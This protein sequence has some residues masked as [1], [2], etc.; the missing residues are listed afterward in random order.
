[1]SRINVMNSPRLYLEAHTYDVRAYRARV[2]SARK[3]SPHEKAS[4]ITE[5]RLRA[6]DELLKGR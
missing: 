1:M 4:D 6:R 3:R 5:Q 2:R